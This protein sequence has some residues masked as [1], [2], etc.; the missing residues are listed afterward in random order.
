MIIQWYQRY[1][2]TLQSCYIHLVSWIH[3]IHHRQPRKIVCLSAQLRPMIALWISVTAKNRTLSRRSSLVY[4]HST[5][6]CMH[7]LWHLQPQ[8]PKR[9]QAQCFSEGHFAK[10][11][12]Q[13]LANDVHADKNVLATGKSWALN[14]ALE[15]RLPL[16]W[17]SQMSFVVVS[18]N[19]AICKQ[20]KGMHIQRRQ[21]RL[22]SWISQSALMTKAAMHHNESEV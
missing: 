13:F 21:W 4:L 15:E 9:S 6:Y 12:L 19:G 5:M 17:L 1:L 18:D 16:H 3:L 22:Q 7:H 11:Y 14:V 2:W 10:S 20:S 8:P